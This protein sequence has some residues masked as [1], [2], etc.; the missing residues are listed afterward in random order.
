MQHGIGVKAGAE[1]PHYPLIGKPGMN[2]DLKDP[3]NPLK[4]FELFCIPEIEEVIARETY[5]YTQKFLENRPNL[6]LQSRIHHWK[7]TN[8]NK[9]MKLLAF[10]PLQGLQQ[11]PD[12]KGH[13]FQRKILETPLFLD[14]FSDRGSTFY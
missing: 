13:F 7:E 11:K 3:R 5:R 2:V 14:L 9:I 12:N 1:R 6:K 8:R 4:C 10:F